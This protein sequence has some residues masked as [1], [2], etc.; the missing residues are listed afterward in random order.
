MPAFPIS[1]PGASARLPTPPTSVSASASAGTVNGTAGA[2]SVSF[3]ASTNPGKPSGN[4]VATSNPGSV[5]ASAASSPITFAAGSLT[6]STSYTFSVVKQSGSGVTSDSTTSGAVVPYTV[7][8]APA[9]LS[10]ARQASQ[11]VRLTFTAP[12]NN[13]GRPITDY[14]YSTNGGVNWRSI[15]STSSPFD[16][17]L[18]SNG[19]ALENGTAYTFTLRAVN[20]AGAGT[21]SSGSSATPF[22][23]PSAPILAFTNTGTTVDWSWSSGGD[24]GSA[25]TGWEYSVSTNDGAYPGNSPRVVNEP[26]YPDSINNSRNTNYYKLR[27]RALNAAG[28]GPYAESANSTNWTYVQGSEVTET[29]YDAFTSSGC[30][31]ECCN[32][33]GSQAKHRRKYSQRQ[34]RTDSWTRPSTTTDTQYVVVTHFTGDT[35]QDGTVDNWGLVSNYTACENNGSCSSISRASFNFASDGTVVNTPSGYRVWYSA[36]GAWG[37]SDASGNLNM[38]WPGDVDGCS[39]QQ[40]C[41]GFATD[42]TYCPGAG[43]DIAFESVGFIVKGACCD[44]F[45]CFWYVCV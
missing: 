29:V 35:N 32:T 25:I 39:G 7:P 24:G 23:I 8:P 22:T 13:G 44:I 20:A 36:Y 11:T 4:Y 19:S 14:Q 12:T 16:A 5:T 34:V 43:C 28:A 10:A 15:G 26:N 33:C 30:T 42:V 31:A 2:V 9:S 1:Q 17:T 40:Q 6:A 45:G 27:V 18:Q 21:A 3:T 37:A 38:P 41:Y